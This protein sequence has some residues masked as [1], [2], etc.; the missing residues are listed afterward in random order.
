MECPECPATSGQESNYCYRGSMT[1]AGARFWSRCGHRLM[2]AREA[3]D[4]PY[5]EGN[6]VAQ[7]LPF[8][9]D[10][11]DAEQV[12]HSPVSRCRQ[13]YRD[14]RCDRSEDLH[15]T[16]SAC[17]QML[18]EIVRGSAGTVTAFSGDGLIAIFGA[19]IAQEVPPTGLLCCPPYAGGDGLLR[20][21]RARKAWNGVLY[22]DRHQPRECDRRHDGP[23]LHGPRRYGQDRSYRENNGVNTQIPIKLVVGL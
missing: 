5:L 8:R 17:F 19:S 3:G 15:Q 21:G 13:L 2:S 10:G 7:P 9:F 6:T 12:Y 22:Q 1:D 20:Q 18:Y 16:I 14:C 23:R 4:G 11:N